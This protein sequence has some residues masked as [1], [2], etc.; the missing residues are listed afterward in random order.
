S[1]RALRQHQARLPAL[2]STETPDQPA[3]QISASFESP[4][5]PSPQQSEQASRTAHRFAGNPHSRMP[6]PKRPNQQMGSAKFQQ[7]RFFELAPPSGVW[8]KAQWPCPGESSLK[9]RA[10]DAPDLD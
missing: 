10:A 7:A 8:R 4:L 5:P 2:L 6:T 1:I 3:K 9:T